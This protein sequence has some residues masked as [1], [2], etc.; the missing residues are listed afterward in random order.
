M[1]SYW[2]FAGKYVFREVLISM[3]Y[4]L[5]IVGGC[6]IEYFLSFGLRVFAKVQTELFRNFRGEFET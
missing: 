1:I 2:N 5:M 3:A 4:R 6:D